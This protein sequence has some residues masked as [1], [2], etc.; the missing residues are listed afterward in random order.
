MMMMMLSNLHGCS[1]CRLCLVSITISVPKDKSVMREKTKRHD[2]YFIKIIELIFLQVRLPLYLGK[3]LNIE[4]SGRPLTCLE[5]EKETLLFKFSQVEK[6]RGYYKKK[7][8]Q[9]FASPV[10]EKPWLLIP[11]L[12]P[13]HSL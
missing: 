10:P 2:T 1:H 7:K 6:Q 4:T 12:V 8:P 11:E 3:I 5:K 9:A 13:H